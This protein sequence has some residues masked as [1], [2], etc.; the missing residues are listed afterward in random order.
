MFGIKKHVLKLGN[1]MVALKQWLEPNQNQTKQNQNQRFSQNHGFGQILGQFLHVL[2]QKVCAQAGKF[3][4]DLKTI[5]GVKPKPNQ[6]KPKP[7]I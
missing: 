3:N 4:G 5:I 7:K 1:W 2:Y 6:T